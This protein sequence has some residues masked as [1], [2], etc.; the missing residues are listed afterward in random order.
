MNHFMKQVDTVYGR[1]RYGTLGKTEQKYLFEDT[2][3]P[4]TPGDWSVYTNEKLRNLF[5]NP[6]LSTHSLEQVHGSKIFEITNEVTSDECPIGDGL[7]TKSGNKIL[8]VR[9]ADCVPVFLFSKKN[10]FV[11]VL[12][13]GWK[14]TK[15]GVTEKMI[16]IYLEFGYTLSD[17]YL[18]LGPY[19][20]GNDYE[21]RED[22]ASEFVGL[23]DGIL[24]QKAVGTYDLDVGNAILSRV[25]TNFSGLQFVNSETKSVFQNPEYFSH[26]A[27][28]FGRNLN[29]IFWEP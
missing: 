6:S 23:G 7:Y 3:F 28:E 1:I 27:K 22:V 12:H 15:L 2:M 10:P 4:N 20:K 24:K 18:D 29:F 13:S 8:I 17:L 21:V 5:P 9:T 25:K 16:Q 14:G 26:R 11:S 19:I